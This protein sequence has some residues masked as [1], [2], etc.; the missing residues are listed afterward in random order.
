MVV[1][2]VMVMMVVMIMH[3]HEYAAYFHG[4]LARLCDVVR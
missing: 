2:V 1:M 3:L 4:G